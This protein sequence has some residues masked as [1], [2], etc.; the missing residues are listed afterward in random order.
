M[1]GFQVNWAGQG[2][3]NMELF[4]AFRV[5]PP[6]ENLQ[7]QPEVPA[8]SPWSTPSPTKKCGSLKDG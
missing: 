4:R 2:S 8:A 5:S 3:E 1:T 7:D 6:G